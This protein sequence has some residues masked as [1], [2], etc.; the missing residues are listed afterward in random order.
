M[1]I[2]LK[3]TYG[4]VLASFMS[5]SAGAEENMT[6][7]SVL[8]SVDG[9]DITV[10]HLI[11]LRGRLPAKYQ[12]LSD[13]VL[14]D[15]MLEQ[16]IQQTV[17]MN[18]IKDNL[19]ERTF[20]SLRNEKRA[21]LASEMMARISERDV[22]DDDLKTA[23]NEQYDG[24]IP[25][26]E[27]NASHVLVETLEEAVIIVGLL[28]DGADFATIARE[29]STGPSGPNGGSLGWFGIGA[30]VKPFEDAVIKLA[31]GEHSP[32]V[33]TQFG[34]HVLIL[35]DMRNLAVPSFDDV[36]LQLAAELQQRSVSDEISRLTSDAKITRIEVAVDPAII[37]DVSLFE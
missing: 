31:I 16:L 35:D 11:A 23:Y 13:T 14:Y 7:K 12:S 34:F 36:R 32:P 5:L 19:D 33:E 24:A 28:D 30:M 37:R 15:G 20:L 3:S 6:A 1:N 2:L 10:G 21:F 27:Y 8:A 26:Q 17:L 29:R 18:A 9:V 22:S 25:E 4:L